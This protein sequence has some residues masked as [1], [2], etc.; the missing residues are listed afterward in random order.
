MRRLYT[1]EVGY[2]DDRAQWH[3]A[4]FDCRGRNIDHGFENDDPGGN[5]AFRAHEAIF[6]SLMVLMNG[7]PR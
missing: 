4:I 5:A 7:G 2:H 1:V 3:W 6:A